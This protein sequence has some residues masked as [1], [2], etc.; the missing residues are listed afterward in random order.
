VRFFIDKNA[1][2][3]S[4]NAVFS[5][6]EYI[7]AFNENWIESL[8]NNLEIMVTCFHES[9]HASQHNVVD[10]LYKGTKIIDT[11]TIIKWKQEISSYHS[12]AGVPSKDNKYL[13]QDI[14]IDAIAFA[15]KMMLEHFD[16]KT[17]IPEKIMNLVLEKL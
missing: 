14:E 6:N 13:F 7:I 3:R 11:E 1:D 10:D 2:N 8:E 15:H 17:I 9:R 5:P 4:I 12:G 16:V